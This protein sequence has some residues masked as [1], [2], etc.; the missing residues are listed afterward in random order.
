MKNFFK[1]YNDV[2]ILLGIFV[3]IIVSIGAPYY[4]NPDVSIVC[5]GVTLS[6]FATLMID[7]F[8]F[9][10]NHN[11][12]LN[13]KLTALGALQ[14]YYLYEYIISPALSIIASAS[15]MVI[16]FRLMNYEHKKTTEN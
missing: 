7:A 16:V 4:K 2:S 3:A 1:N 11:E 8:K 12:V 15:L 10:N 9:R 14:G 5:L 13:A 6:M